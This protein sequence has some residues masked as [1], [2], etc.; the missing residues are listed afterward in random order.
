V[1]RN[2]PIIKFNSSARRAKLFV[3]TLQLSRGRT[4]ILPRRVWKKVHEG[5]SRLLCVD[6]ELIVTCLPKAEFKPD[7]ASY[8]RHLEAKVSMTCPKCAQTVCLACGEEVRKTSDMRKGGHIK[9]YR[10]QKLL[11]CPNLQVSMS[12]ESYQTQIMAEL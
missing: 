4:T 6:G 1:S 11:H 2:A 12:G 7:F 3:P 8:E 5:K 10:E 9:P